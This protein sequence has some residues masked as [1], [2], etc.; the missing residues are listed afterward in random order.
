M[1]LA[2]NLGNTDLQVG[3]FDGDSL[4]FSTRI[5]TSRERSADETAI[6]LGALFSL[7]GVPVSAV[8]SAVFSSVVRPLNGMLASAIETLAGVK[9]L[10]VGPGVR[11]GLDIRT[12]VASQLGADIVANAVAALALAPAPLV[13]VDFGTATTLTGI[14]GHG[15]LC[16]VL[17]CPGVR[18][19]LD[20]LS[21]AAAELPRIAV[22]GPRTL[23]GKNTVDSMTSGAVYGH[24]A[25]VDGLLD[26][27]AQEWSLE[28]LTVVM[29]GTWAER[30]APYCSGR[31]GVHL[32]PDLT[33]RGLKRIA[34]MNVR[35]KK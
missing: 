27:V 18:I 11:T 12:D 31:H 10:Q 8:D 35:T 3:A 6:L 9:P 29:T 13:F 33:L 20:A 26:R 34:E 22:D 28:G 25:M 15:E 16:G 19:S 2:C 4:R 1:L 32:Q 5:A 23:F 21:E 14:N 24:A 17:I 30:I 7:H